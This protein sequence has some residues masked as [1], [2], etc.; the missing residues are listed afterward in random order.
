M[1]QRF[2]PEP[3][4][5]PV[6]IFQ[7]RAPTVPLDVG[8][9]QA[10][11]PKPQE[12]RQT[13]PT[14]PACSEN[15]TAN[16]WEEKTFDDDVDGAKRNKFLR[17]MGLKSKVIIF[18][19]WLAHY[20]QEAPPPPSAPA[21]TETKFV[22]KDPHFGLFFNMIFHSLSHFGTG[23]SPNWSANTR[24]AAP[25]SLV[26]A[27]AQL[28]LASTLPRLVSS[29]TRTRTRTH[30]HHL[31]LNRAQFS[32]AGRSCTSKSNQDLRYQTDRENFFSHP[33]DC[34]SWPIG[35]TRVRTFTIFVI[36][37]KVCATNLGHIVSKEF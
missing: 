5:P 14:K 15:L 35:V 32:V 19:I 37:R 27:G 22:P 29:I 26:L 17:L 16:H 6:V 34:P 2:G 36:C 13:P 8:S 18:R 21:K 28:A 30:K 25:D 11:Q 3:T 12:V 31:I 4:T 20:S 1:G 33:P 7:Q 10:S 23:F 9:S 24:R